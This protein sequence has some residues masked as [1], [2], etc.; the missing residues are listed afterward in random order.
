[1]VNAQG[2]D[3]PNSASEREGGKEE[4]VEGR[5]GP[6]GVRGEGGTLREGRLEAPVTAQQLGSPRREVWGRKPAAGLLQDVGSKAEGR[7]GDSSWGRRCRGGTDLHRVRSHGGPVRLGVVVVEARGTQD[8]LAAQGSWAEEQCIAA[9]E[10]PAPGAGRGQR[11]QWGVFAVLRAGSEVG[12]GLR[13]K[14]CRGE[15]KAS[16]EGGVSRVW[17]RGARVNARRAVEA[18]KR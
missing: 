10:R 12:L 1:M 5:E 9:T 6:R 8:V 14:A 15:G 13:G 4:R 11:G 3:I 7:R 16:G 2:K 17:R 18:C